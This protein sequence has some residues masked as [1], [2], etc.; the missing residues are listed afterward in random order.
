[1]QSS[2]SHPAPPTHQMTYS[3]RRR[4][5]LVLDAVMTL[6][7]L[8]VGF[9]VGAIVYNIERDAW[10][11]RQR[12]AATS[13]ARA[14]ETFLSGI[15]SHLDLVGILDRVYLSTHSEDLEA[16]LQQND[17]LLEIV[18]ANAN[19]DVFAGAYRD[20]PVLANLF[21]VPQSTWFLQARRGMPY[22]GKVQ[23]S[24]DDTPYLIM[25]VPTPEGDVVAARLRIDLLWDI[26]AGVQFGQTGH[27]YVVNLEGE[28]IAHPDREIVLDYTRIRLRP[29]MQA[30]L[31][32]PNNEWYGAYTN[33]A[34]QDV[35]GSTVALARGEWIIFTEIASAEASVTAVR[36]II[37][38]GGGILL[39]SIMLSITI[40]YLMKSL[41]FDKLRIL[42]DGAAQIGSGDLDHR[43]AVPQRNEIGQLAAAFNEMAIQLKER[44]TELARA[45]DEAVEASNFK[46]RLLANVSHDL[47]TPLNAMMGYTEILREGVHGTLSETQLR[48]SERVMVNAK[49]LLNM[50]NSLLDQAQIEAGK[51]KLRFQPFSPHELLVESQT[52]MQF[53]AEAKGL[54]FM[55][56]IDD[57]LPEMLMGDV[58]RLQQIII[59]LV[60]NAVKFTQEGSVQIRLF[61][62][63]P[64]YW[65]IAVSDSGP[66]VP[67]EAQQYIFEPFRQLDG[68]IT[69]EQRGV[70]LGLSIVKQLAQ[71]MGGAVDLQSKIGKGSTFIVK[72]PLILPYEDTHD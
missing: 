59:N 68:S 41:I 46:S 44:E 13:A 18:R 64:T 50:I 43:I 67:P 60:D 5:M 34:G 28:I 35:V 66:G 65:A 47:R 8:V 45:R 62:A 52:I 7:V 36:A 17:A 11:N 57:D 38:I 72:L 33:F 37:A 19:G 53:A 21:T 29:E 61:Q 58:Q 71:M 20:S 1:M 49:R 48:I 42:Q 15:Q 54:D 25:A 31:E 4:L 55:L 39:I 26:I 14:V 3:L 32:A 16:L 24:A 10:R 30:A 27:A 23:I 2:S 22:F 56:E 51:L 70:G 9:S 6:I 63:A 69:R 40:N 12:E